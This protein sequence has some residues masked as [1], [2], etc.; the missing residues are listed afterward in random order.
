MSTS[1]SFTYWGIKIFYCLELLFLLHL[2]IILNSYLII[3]H[4]Y[5]IHYIWK[6]SWT[7]SVHFNLRLIYKRAFI[8]PLITFKI[9]L[10]GAFEWS[11]CWNSVL[12][13]YSVVKII[14]NRFLRLLLTGG[15]YL[16]SF[17]NVI[18]SNTIFGFNS[19]FLF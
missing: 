14:I 8:L 18:R 7:T 4:R 10:G 12:L 15:G 3:L 16:K 1:F 9:I 5:L 6:R 17:Q 2:L 11:I 13:Q 19:S